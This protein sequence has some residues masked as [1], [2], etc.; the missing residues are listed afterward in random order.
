[1]TQSELSEFLDA[2]ALF[3]PEAE[4]D[5]MEGQVICYSGE[6]YL[7]GIPIRDDIVAEND[8]GLTTNLDDA[9][10]SRQEIPFIATDNEGSSQKIKGKYCR[11]MYYVSTALLLMARKQ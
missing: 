9:L 6:K 2:P 3:H 10:S 4:K 8:E 1:M 7:S 5:K 11:A